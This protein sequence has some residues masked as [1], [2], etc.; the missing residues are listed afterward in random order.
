MQYYDVA[1]V[2]TTHGLNGEVKVSVITD[3]PEDRFAVGMHLA[4]KNNTEDV[5]TVKK[6]RPFKQF[7][8]VQFE[9]IKDIDAAEKL[10]GQVL[11]VSEDDRGELPE[12]AYYYKDIFDCDVID[13]ESGARLGKITDIQSPG[14]N[15]VWLVHEDSG[16]EYWIPNIA[17]VVKKVDVANKKVYVE[18]MEGLR[19]ED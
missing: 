11:V 10:R 16:K 19:D 6:G 4:L 13:N 18:L 9:E 15:D 1:R 7:W 8:L 12:G 2:L 3:F 14:A 17:D 5:L